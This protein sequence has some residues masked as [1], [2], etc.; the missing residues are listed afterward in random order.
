VL[1]GRVRSGHDAALLDV[2]IE[3]WLPERSWVRAGM[4]LIGWGLPADSLFDSVELQVGG[5]WVSTKQ[6]EEFGGCNTGLPQD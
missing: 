5:L 4:A 1:R 2:R 6:C 3:H